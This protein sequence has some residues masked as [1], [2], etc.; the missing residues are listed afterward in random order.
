MYTMYKDKCVIE[1]K[2]PV[3]EKVYRNIFVKITII[4][5]ISLKDQCSFCT[6]YLQ[7]KL[8]GTLIPEMENDFKKHMERKAEA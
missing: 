1:K 7:H 2:K 8:N 6:L 5:F 4:P 3:T